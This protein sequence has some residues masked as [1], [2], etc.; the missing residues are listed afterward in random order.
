M[1]WLNREIVNSRTYQLSWKPNET[2]RLDQR[3]FSHAIPRRLPAE[4]AIDA[5]RQATAS[6]STV[7]AL[8]ADCRDRA[9]GIPGQKH[10]GRGKAKYALGVFGVSARETNCDC[11]R[12]NDPSLLQTIFLRNDDEVQALIDDPRIGWVAQVGD[13]LRSSASVSA[14]AP[15][16]QPK[17]SGKSRPAR[18]AIGPAELS[19]AKQRQLIQTA[20]LR[21]LSRYPDERELSRALAHLDGGPDVISGLRDVMW[22]L[23]NTQEFIV[24]H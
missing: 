16:A 10:Q 19:S 8:N 23:V 5:V 21:S 15:S 12:S 24:N 11:S 3:N 14:S 17:T 22:A 7:A 1:K 9:I 6:D 20:Y 18:V 4:V 2:N 13:E